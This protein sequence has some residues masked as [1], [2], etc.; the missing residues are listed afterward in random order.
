MSRRPPRDIES[1]IRDGTAIDRAIVAARRRRR[2]GRHGGLGN[3]QH[4]REVDLVKKQAHLHS[5][6]TPRKQRDGFVAEAAK[7][8]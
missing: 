1:I 2:S 5:G 8:L 4:Q 3:S 7:R 6:V